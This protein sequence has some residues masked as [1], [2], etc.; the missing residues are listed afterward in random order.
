MRGSRGNRTGI[1]ALS[2]VLALGLVACGDDD[3]DEP[4]A[5]AESA[6]AAP[7]GSAT[8][9][10]DMIDHGYQVSGALIAGGRLKFAN[11][12]NEFHMVGLGRFKAGKTLA[13][14]QKVLREA[15]PTTAEGGAAGGEDEQGPTAEILDEVGLPGSFMGPGESAEVTLPD[16]QPGTYALICFIR[17]EGE[18]APHFEHGMVGQLDVVPGQAP[19]PPMADVTYKVAP[20][21]AVEGPATLTAG[22]H[23]IKF[24]AAP[25]SQQL[26][27]SV[28]R[29]NPGATYG[30]L[31]AAFIRLFESEEA[32]AK[33]AAKAAPGQVIFG[34][35]DLQDVTSFFLTVDLKPGNHVI[36]AEDTD[37]DAPGTPLELIAVRVR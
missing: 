30:Q 36:V 20:G 31:D 11:K 27:P 24:E 9:T 35:S 2:A 25:G 23:T 17:T 33:G 1:V 15:R 21:K 3:D 28:V 29:L 14:L 5:P 19:P 4:A 32:P 6:T 26:E 16:L 10:I 7:R 8:V 18:G 34:G 13:D 12:G 22:R 37:E